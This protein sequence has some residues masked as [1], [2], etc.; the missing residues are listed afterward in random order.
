MSN[1][2]SNGLKLQISE[3]KEQNS[4]L[5]ARL[6]Q[7]EYGIEQKKQFMLAEK[8]DS[9]EEEAGFEVEKLLKHRKKG[10][11]LEFLVRW[12]GFEAKDDTWE[13]ESN[14]ECPSNICKVLAAYKNKN[15]I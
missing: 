5:Q 9:E 12:K 4:S 11:T 8:T 3:L 1:E 2:Q 14:L 6:K 13:P 10:K 7:A 15:K